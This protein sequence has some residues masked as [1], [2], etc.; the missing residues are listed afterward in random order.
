[1]THARQSMRVGS[2]QGNERGFTLLEALIAMAVMSIAFLGLAGLQAVALH[3]NVDA[4]ELT[5]A[6]NLAT[7]MLERIHSNRTNA[8]DY[9]GALGTGLDSN[10]NATKPP[11]TQPTARGDFEM[12]QANLNN[13]G[14][15]NVQGLVNAVNPFGPAGLG[16]TQVVVQVRWMTQ[17]GHNKVTRQAFVNLQTVLTPQVDT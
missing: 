6:S 5:R 16:Q 14:L 10:D 2:T 3:Y 12:W 17:S 7:E 9:N 15:N 8:T 1:M 4:A 13:S 11:T